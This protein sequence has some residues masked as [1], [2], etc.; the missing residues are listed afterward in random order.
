MVGNSKKV[1]NSLTFA[2]AGLGT[3]LREHTKGTRRHIHQ[4]CKMYSKASH[5][6]ATVIQVIPIASVFILDIRIRQTYRHLR[7]HC[8]L[9]KTL[10]M[11]T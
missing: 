11:V 7:F 8:K 2:G 4:A 9:P 10:D 3:R 6:C 5:T 1:V